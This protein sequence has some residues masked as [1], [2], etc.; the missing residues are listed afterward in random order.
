MTLVRALLELMRPHQWIKNLVVLAPLFFGKSLLEP[1]RLQ[2]A[3][4]VFLLFCLLSS[5]VYV[6]NDIWDVEADRKH[7]KKSLRPLPS[8]AVS[9]AMAWGLLAALAAAFLVGFLVLVSPSAALSQVFLFYLAA[10]LAYTVGLKHVSIVELFFVASGYVL[11]LIAGA[12]AVGIVLS[13]WILVCTAL[14][15]LLVVVGKRRADLTQ[16]ND[17]EGA[18]RVLQ[19]YTLPFLDSLMV[20]LGASTLL[21]YLMFCVSEYGVLRYGSLVPLTAIFVAVGLFRFL[22]VVMME[23]GGDSPSDLFVKDKVIAV[24]VLG[25]VG[26]FFLLLYI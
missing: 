16:L 15:A 20:L 24:A 5:T 26:T 21:T 10:N 9:R 8:G 18:R 19:T 12:V 3:L 4:S 25:W 11:R 17:P 2:G 14:G 22:Q 7:K 6:F 13:S 1:D 23:G